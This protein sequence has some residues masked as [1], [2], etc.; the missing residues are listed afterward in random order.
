MHLFLRQF[1]E[2]IG[3]TDQTR[4]FPEPKAEFKLTA[5]TIYRYLSVANFEYSQGNL[6]FRPANHK[7]HQATL[8]EAL[9]CADHLVFRSN[10][11]A[12]ITS[13]QS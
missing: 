9:T 8:V 12:M 11:S 7:P 6:T 2:Q 10:V 5:V 4:P 1:T 3:D 13:V